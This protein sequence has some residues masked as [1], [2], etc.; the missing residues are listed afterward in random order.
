MFLSIT[1]CAVIFSTIARAVLDRLLPEAA[2]EVLLPPD[3]AE[4][5]GV[6]RLPPRGR[7]VVVLARP[8]VR[9]RVEPVERLAS[10]GR[11]VQARLV[12]VRG[13]GEEDVHASDRVHDVGERREADLHVVVD[14]DAEILMDRVDQQIRTVTERGVDLLRAVAGDRNPRVARN[15][16]EEPLARRLRVDVGDH[17][18]VG[19]VLG[20]RARVTEVRLRDLV[21]HEVAAV[22]T[23]DQVVGGLGRVAGDA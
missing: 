12:V 11:D 16:D 21:V 19:E 4:V 22:G 2:D 1:R 14:R 18:H 7:L 3:A 23:D 6:V 13:R 15:R 17:D 8:R 5:G 20:I 10:R 9:E